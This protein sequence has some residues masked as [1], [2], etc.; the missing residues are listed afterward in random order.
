MCICCT[1]AFSICKTQTPQS[2]RYIAK[3]IKIKMRG[4]GEGS[5]KTET[6]CRSPY[7]KLRKSEFNQLTDAKVNIV[8]SEDLS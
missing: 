7:Y 8:G 4:R 2:D 5:I 1:M 6:H 3:K